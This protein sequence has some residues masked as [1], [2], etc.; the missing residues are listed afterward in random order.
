[1]TRNQA[2]LQAIE[3]DLPYYH[4]QRMAKLQA[5]QARALAVKRAKPDPDAKA[6]EQLLQA[7]AQTERDK[8]DVSI[9]EREVVEPLRQALLAE[10][11]ES[12]G[13]TKV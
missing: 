13:S 9:T 5:E 10:K 3:K 2:L 7:I 6:I 8:R 11:P 12:S 1:M 4:P